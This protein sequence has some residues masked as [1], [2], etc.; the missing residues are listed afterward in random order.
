LEESPAYLQKKVLPAVLLGIE[1]LLRL[2]KEGK[3]P[4]NPLSFLALVI[5]YLT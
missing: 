3:E 4:L 2:V 5:C 1:R